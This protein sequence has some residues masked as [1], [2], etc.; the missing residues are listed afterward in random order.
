MGYITLLHCIYRMLSN[1]MSKVTLLRSNV[2]YCAKTEQLFI[3]KYML[4]FYWFI[5]KKLLTYFIFFNLSQQ[6]RGEILGFR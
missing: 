4:L 3:K 6:N 2:P 5:K 1:T